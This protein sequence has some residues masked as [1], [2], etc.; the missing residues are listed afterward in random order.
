MLILDLKKTSAKNA[1]RCCLV[2]SW[3]SNKKNKN[4]SDENRNKTSTVLVLGAGASRKQGASSYHY[5]LICKVAVVFTLIFIVVRN[6]IDSANFVKVPSVLMLIPV[7]SDMN[8]TTSS[9]IML[10]NTEEVETTNTT[11]PT[12][13]NVDAEKTLGPLLLLVAAKPATGKKKVAIEELETLSSFCVTWNE[14][15]LDK[16][17]THHIEYV[18]EHENTTHQCFRRDNTSKRALYLSRLYDNQFNASNCENNVHLRYLWN[19]G[20]GTFLL[21]MSDALQVDVI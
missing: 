11:E 15:N 21:L 13:K 20:W 5:Q 16:W 2:S 8:S 10:S 1:D 6:L 18:V 14:I 4:R 9:R 17:L 12:R 19:W 3:S 7:T